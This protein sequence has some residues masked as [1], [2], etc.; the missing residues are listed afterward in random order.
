MNVSDILRQN[1]GMIKINAYWSGITVGAD[2]ERQAR[3]TKGL[4]MRP[5]N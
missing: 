1:M 4:K 3:N 5:F 2:S